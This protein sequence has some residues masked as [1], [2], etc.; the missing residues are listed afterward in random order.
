VT[1]AAPPTGKLGFFLTPDHECN[2]LEGRVARTVF[3]DPDAAPPR[4][5]QTALA[6]AGFRRS[7]RFIY[8]P[9][10]AACQACIPV[11]IPAYDF[12][13]DRGQRRAL[14]ANRRLL[15]RPVPLE[16]ND[17]HLDL[18]MRYQR[19]RHT[20]GAMHTDS[21]EAF[22]E[23][24][25]SSFSDTWLYEMRED[26]ALLGVMVVDHLDDALSS[27]YTF[28]DPALPQRSLGT[29]AVLWQVAEARRLGMRWVYLGYWIE[30]C[31][32]MAYKG[33]FQPFERLTDGV[34]RRGP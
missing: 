33:R 22:L 24:F 29:W 26:G 34:W 13:P 3:A 28:F 6:A 17:E 4:R 5:V 32:K 1:R 31:R 7:G 16:R 18:Y 8:R 25:A 30:E 2:Y 10:C 23:F 20:D 9:Q 19:S 11:R 14:R 15:V 21:P 12:V 27:V